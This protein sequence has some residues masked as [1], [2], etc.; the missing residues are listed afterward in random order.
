M[1][2]TLTYVYSPQLNWHV[3]YGLDLRNISSNTL[4]CK[5]NGFR[6][7]NLFI[8]GF[9]TVRD[10]HF[11]GC[12]RLKCDNLIVVRWQVHLSGL[13]VRVRI[14]GSTGLKGGFPAAIA[15]VKLTIVF[16]L[17]G[18]K[19]SLKDV[20]FVRGT[21]ILSPAQ[22]VWTRILH[23]I[24]AL[25]LH[26]NWLLSSEPGV[27]GARGVRSVRRRVRQANLSGNE[28]VCAS[29]SLTYCQSL[30]SADRSARDFRA[31]G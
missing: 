3:P 29:A 14:R 5:S 17:V 27:L 24:R 30:C 1:T 2:L 18:N 11:L 16:T 23:R 9:P 12:T 22:S 7:F 15:K 10:L 19:I 25:T 26:Q 8:F 13:W 4:I 31:S 21:T 6:I 20:S 28:K